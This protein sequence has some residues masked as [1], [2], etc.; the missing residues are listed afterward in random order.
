MSPV[1]FT[2]FESALAEYLQQELAL[3]TTLA[4]NGWNGDMAEQVLLATL[5]NTPTTRRQQRQ[6]YLQGGGGEGNNSPITVSAP[7]ATRTTITAVQNAALPMLEQDAVDFYMQQELQQNS[8]KFLAF[9]TQ[10]TDSPTLLVYFEKIKVVTWFPEEQNVLDG[11]S[12]ASVLQDANDDDD[13][14]EGFFTMWAIV[15]IVGGVGFCLLVI[16]VSMFAFL[17]PETIHNSPRQQASPRHGGFSTSPTK[18]PTPNN[19]NKVESNIAAANSYED[20]EDTTYYGNA[21]ILNPPTVTPYDADNQSYAYSLE[22]GTFTGGGD[23]VAGQSK[24]TTTV[25][26]TVTPVAKKPSQRGGTAA[27]TP[28]TPTTLTTLAGAAA[29]AAAADDTTITTTRRGP[30]VT[31]QVHAPPGKLGIVIDTS[32]EGPIVHKVNE[33][34][35]LLGKIFQGDIITSINGIDTRAMKA[36]AITTIMVRTAH[37]PRVLTVA[38]EDT[39]VG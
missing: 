34:S 3:K 27:T 9:L 15:G 16:V 20:G 29:A 22:P 38:S 28:K 36:S 25:A 18:L 26:T 8:D 7:L 12:R 6:R 10:Q 14:D 39:T 4:N 1:H 24:A 30:M 31:R 32:L 11:P 13:D 35:P 5:P 23:T 37:E 33:N 17:Q 2:Y 21:S 19:S